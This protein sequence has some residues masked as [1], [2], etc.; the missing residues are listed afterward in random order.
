L[1]D[2]TLTPPQLG[3]GAPGWWSLRRRIAAL[4]ALNAEADP[5][6]R[7]ALWGNVA[8]GRICTEVP[9]IRVGYFNSV[10]ARSPKLEGYVPMPWPFFW[11]T[12]W[13]VRLRSR[14]D[15][16]SSYGVGAL[17]FPALPRT[18]LPAEEGLG[19]RGGVAT[20]L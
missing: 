20:L 3:D 15:R 5:K 19:V 1:P 17:T 8:V 9:Y 7:G 4:A 6:K 2:P 16:P 10:T 11:N 12:G 18:P 13:S 14:I